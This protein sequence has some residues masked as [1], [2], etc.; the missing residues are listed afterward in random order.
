M[1]ARYFI[2]Q[3][4]EIIG[5][6]VQTTNRRHADFHVSKGNNQFYAHIKRLNLDKK[7]KVM[8]RL[9]DLRKKGG[10]YIL[11]KQLTD[12]EMQQF[13]KEA[14]KFL[15]KAKNGDSQEIKNSIGERL[16]EVEKATING[17]TV[18]PPI[19]GSD[20]IKYYNMLSDAYK[21]FMP[22]SLNIIFVTSKWGDS[23]DADKA[24]S[25]FLAKPSHSDASIIVWFEYNNKDI[26]CTK[27]EIF[28]RESYRNNCP[29]Y[30]NDLFGSQVTYL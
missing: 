4:W 16:G 24:I 28:V 9:N 10:S 14:K 29:S 12:R 30:I 26:H 1:L 11:Y 8:N 7:F 18:G 22:H 2:T 17:L 3:G 25:S 15:E 5:V 6:E 23:V 19:E 27:F 13:C 21:Q 20:E